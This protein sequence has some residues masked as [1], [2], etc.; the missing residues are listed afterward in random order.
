MRRNFAAII[1]L[2]FLPLF[3]QALPPQRD[4]VPVRHYILDSAVPS[5]PPPAPS[6]PRRDRSPA[7]A[8]KSPLPGT[9][10]RRRDASE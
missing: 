9:H 8:G 7:S 4:D 6:S 10:A 2:L 3:A 5:M 1:A